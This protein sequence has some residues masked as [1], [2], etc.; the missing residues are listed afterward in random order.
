MIY[1]T[2]VVQLEYLKYSFASSLRIVLLQHGQTEWYLKE[3][4]ISYL[5]H[6]FVIHSECS[7]REGCPRELARSPRC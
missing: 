7:F 3:I 4:C 1:C 5:A 6:S 2:A